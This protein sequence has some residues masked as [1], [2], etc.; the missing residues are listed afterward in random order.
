MA[1]EQSRMGVLVA[2]S[3]AWQERSAD[4]GRAQAEYDWLGPLCYLAAGDAQCVDALFDGH[5][6]RPDLALRPGL[7]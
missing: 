3:A 6:G 2:G 1:M 7:V 5:H 4:R